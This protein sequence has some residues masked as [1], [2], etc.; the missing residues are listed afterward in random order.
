[1]GTHPGCVASICDTSQYAKELAIMAGK[2]YI[3]I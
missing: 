2:S 1:M 3:N